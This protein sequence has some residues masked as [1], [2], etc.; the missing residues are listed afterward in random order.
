MIFSYDRP[1]KPA[2]HQY[3]ICFPDFKVLEFNYQVV[4]L[5]RL[6]WRDFLNQPN[7]VASALMAKMKIEPNDRPRVKAE[8]LRLLATLKLNPAKMQL[9]SGFVDTYL[10]LNRTEEIE[11]QQTIGEFQPP[12]QENV[13]QIV[14]SWMQQGIEQGI[15]QGR[16]RG[17]KILVLRQL[18]RKLGELNP[19]VQDQIMALS[20]EQV[21]NLGDALLDFVTVH[22]LHHWLDRHSVLTPLDPIEPS[23]E[24]DQTDSQP[25]AKPAMNIDRFAVKFPAQATE[26][27]DQ[28]SLIPILHEWIREKSLPGT[29][30]D[31]AD[32][33]HVPDGPGIMLITY[34]INYA[35]DQGNGQLG[36]YAQRKVGSE[37]SQ[38]DRIADLLRS[39]QQ[40]GSLLENDRRLA[41]QIAF[42]GNEF[43]FIANDRLHAPNTPEAFAAIQGDLAAAIQQLYPGKTV[44]LTQVQNDPRDRLTVKVEST[45]ATGFSFSSQT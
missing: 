6:N 20:L 8:C 28:G 40:F 24:S 21:E 3:Q 38:A 11:F 32:Y 23:S 17:E 34:E 29:L 4:Q 45:D 33:R 5:N 19:R 14:T 25:I 9:I 1:L 41:G 27:F 31:V 15:E 18:R 13:M 7:P 10:K 44:S 42:K 39:T 36:L 37:G 43:S 2:Q 16:K 12:Q 22:E 30:L 26:T 35:L